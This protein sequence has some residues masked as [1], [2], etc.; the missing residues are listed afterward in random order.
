MKTD[1]ATPRPWK[2][3]KKFA[4]VIGSDDWPVFGNRYKD[5]LRANAKLIVRAVNAHDQLVKT[6]E[7]LLDAIE[8][9]G[10][11]DHYDCVIDDCYTNAR[12]ALKLAKGE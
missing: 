8:S 4:D 3:D 11:A 9:E 2:F 10:E 7:D 12:N 6:L 1:K 5:E